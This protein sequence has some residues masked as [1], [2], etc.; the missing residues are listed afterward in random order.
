M[1]DKSLIHSSGYWLIEDPYTPEHVFDCNIAHMLVDLFYGFAVVDLGCGFGHYVSYLRGN[2]IDCDGFDGNPFTE[3][4]SH[5]LC[6]S[7]DLSQPFKLHKPYKGILSLEVAEHIPIQ[8][9][10]NYIDNLLQTVPDIIVL[11]WA[12]PGQPGFGHTNGKTSEEI[13][14]LMSNRKYVYSFNLSKKF[15]DV[16]LYSWFK[17]S[18][19][20][21]LRG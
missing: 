21:F 8:F 18:I 7:G 20:V 16:S 1:T 13:I 6:K 11:S 3:K 19:F 15:R 2:N 17:N 5:G 10:N 14:S 12:Y 4:N 9:E